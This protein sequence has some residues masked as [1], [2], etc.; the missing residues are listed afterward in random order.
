MVKWVWIRKPAI[1]GGRN[2]RPAQRRS[3]ER[4]GRRAVCLGFL[5]HPRRSN[6]LRKSRRLERW[7]G[8]LPGK[9]GRWSTAEGV[10][11]A[12][13]RKRGG[14]IASSRT[15]KGRNAGDKIST[16]I[17]RGG[18]GITQEGRRATGRRRK[19]RAELRINEDSSTRRFKLI[20]LPLI[21]EIA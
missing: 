21:S 19:Q 10:P 1:A 7:L 3:A 11:S 18:S 16:E 15:G 14:P 17:D 20:D 5:L 12:V 13:P 4:G 2:S 6:H 8:L 9:P